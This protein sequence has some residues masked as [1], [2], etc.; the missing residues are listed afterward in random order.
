MGLDAGDEVILPAN[1]Y[2]SALS[3]ALQLNAIPRLCDVGHDSNIDVSHMRS[4]VGPRTRLVVPVHLYG[5]PAD[6]SSV[7]SVAKEHNLAVVEDCGQGHGATFNG[8]PMGDYGDCAAFSFFTCK[9]VT[10]GEGGMA[11]TDDETIASRLRELCHKGKGIGWYDYRSIGYSYTMTELQAAA[12]MVTLAEYDNEV[13]KRVEYGN[14]YKKELRKLGLEVVDT[15]EHVQSS[16]FKFPFYLPREFSRFAEW[17]ER[18]C[19]AENVVVARG[20][21]HL[22]RIP[23]I[24]KKEY[25]A[26]R[27][28]D[29][30]R[31]ASYL[32]E[33]TPVANDLTAR[34][35]TACTGPGITWNDVHN[36]VEAIS[37]VYRTLESDFDGICQIEAIAH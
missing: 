2:V 12:G 34:T 9:H 25:S 33:D 4:L 11:L 24:A 18:A 32:P 21:P 26:W 37:K 31:N 27:L 19:R 29:A 1:A 3:A 20:Y 8:H 36:T 15:L 23:W 17:F 16:Y 14:H 13:A 28:T 7:M 30:G 10:T 35:L 5:F 6:M 22:A